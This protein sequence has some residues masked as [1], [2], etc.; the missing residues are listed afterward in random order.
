[1]VNDIKHENGHSRIAKPG[2]KARFLLALAVFIS[3]GCALL[4]GYAVPSVEPPRPLPTPEI[5]SDETPGLAIQILY[6]RRDSDG[7]RFTVNGTGFQPGERIT[8][9]I[10]AQGVSKAVTLEVLDY[11][12]QP[13]GTFSS[14]DV[15]PEE[16]PNMR[17]EVHA[18]HQRGVACLRTAPPK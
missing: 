8:L 13:D 18:V 7:Q 9:R 11:P 12:V 4:P 10:T 14:I 2:W 17:W 6:G 16:E 15:M 3:L 5:C 1:M